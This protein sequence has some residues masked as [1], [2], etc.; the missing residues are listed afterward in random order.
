MLL[1]IGPEA[2]VAEGYIDIKEYAKVKASMELYKLITATFTDLTS[3]DNH[4]FYGEPGVGKSKRA[5]QLYPNAYIKDP[6]SI[7]FTGYNGEIAII[8]DDFEPVN[9]KQSGLLKRLADH[10]PTVVRVHGSQVKIRP[11]HI[12]ITSNFHPNEIWEGKYLEP[13]LRRF[14]V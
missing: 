5:R 10:Y 2:A 8:I 7:W 11:A 9:R 1:S 6:D 4:W 3:L 12:I 14:K 13:I